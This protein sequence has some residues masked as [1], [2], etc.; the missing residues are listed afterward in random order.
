MIQALD[1][2]NNPRQENYSQVST[3]HLSCQWKVDEHVE[4]EGR[5]RSY[6]Q[7]CH[8]HTLINLGMFIQLSFRI[9]SSGHLYPHFPASEQKHFSREPVSAQLQ[10]RNEGTGVFLFEEGCTYF[11]GDPEEA[12][13]SWP[14]RTRC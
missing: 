14:D 3:C 12:V 13:P 8:G 5:G 9:P 4:P 11:T 1:G 6:K 10:V 2:A 7:L